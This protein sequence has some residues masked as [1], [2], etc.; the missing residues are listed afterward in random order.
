M[1]PVSQAS[2]FN[3]L[4][5]A[6]LKNNILQS[7]VIKKAS[8]DISKK[9]ISNIS[10]K[11]RYLRKTKYYDDILQW[12]SEEDREKIRLKTPYEGKTHPSALTE[13]MGF[14]F[15]ISRNSPTHKKTKTH[16]CLIFIFY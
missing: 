10:S 12:Y 15:Y 11:L 4:E 3:R 9:E 5:E 8:D 7:G 14:K 2:Q 1:T 6:L 16:Q 13:I